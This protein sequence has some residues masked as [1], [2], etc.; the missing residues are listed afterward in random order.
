M[1]F[2]QQLTNKW[3]DKRIPA[4]YKHQ[5]NHKNVFILPAKFGGLFLV[6][7][8]LLFLLGTNYQNNLMLLLCYFLL[9]LFLINLLASYVN[10]SKLL[11]Q[12]GKT[13]EVF[14][15]DNLHL[16]FWLNP[17]SPILQRPNGLFYLSFRTAEKTP[18]KTQVDLN[19]DNNP[20]TI[21]YLCHKRG[22]LTLPRV[23]IASYF[24]LG[25]FKCWTHLAF[26]HDILVYPKPQPCVINLLT[27]TDDTNV[28]AG[29]S[30]LE[31]IGHDEFLQLKPYQAGEPLHH[32]AWKQLA[33]GRGMI[34]K[35]FST[36][37]QQTA[38]LKL[39]SQF[40]QQALNNEWLETE[41]S[42]LTFQVIEVAKTE[43]HFG[44]DLGQVCIAPNT[45][46][47]HTKK[48]LTALALFPSRVN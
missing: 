6:L 27:N 33:K 30:Q 12:Q 21:S 1:N 18:N 35:Q 2:L 24:P 34:S 32:V 10:F 11:I 43:Q 9:A 28:K 14:V 3:L 45:G 16:P 29:S 48:C 38:W 20:A 26:S 41:L 4:A 37:G 42:K 19:A 40:K 36:L 47:E 25:L 13:P 15:G 31:Q 22:K 44:L 39:P 23:T 17:D 5:L 7:C 46:P 8:F